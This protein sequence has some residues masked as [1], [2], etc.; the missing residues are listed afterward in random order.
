VDLASGRIVGAE[1]LIRWH[2]PTLGLQ[3][4]DLFIPLAEES[5]LIVPLGA[6]VLRTGI[7]SLREWPKF[8]ATRTKLAINVSGVQ[9]ERGDLLAVLNEALADGH[10]DPT[11]IELE[12]TESSLIHS[13]DRAVDILRAIRGQ[14]IGIAIDDFGT[15]YSSFQ[16]VRELPI[17]KLKID[18]SF[19]RHLSPASSD[20]SIVRAIIGLGKSMALDVVAEG[21]ETALQ[22]QFL[23]GEG[24]RVG[25]GYYFSPPLAEEDLLRKLRQNSIL[26]TS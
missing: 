7:R 17:T 13:S 20:A 2:H 9:L 22:R 5:G 16:Y 21:V 4:P 10:I 19:V 11:Q 24:C 14:G 25:Q 15:G 23:V 6:W 8:G 1:A 18:Q 26:P 12:L 3:R